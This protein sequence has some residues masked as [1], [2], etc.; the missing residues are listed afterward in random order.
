MG[1]AKM[2]AGWSRSRPDSQLRTAPHRSRIEIKG[3][4]HDHFKMWFLRW[5]STGDA[6]LTIAQAFDFFK[7]NGRF[8]N[9]S[10]AVTM[11]YIIV[12]R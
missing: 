6:M 11:N 8:R 3:P 5:V 2:Q 9:S 10:D 12:C 7:A 1:L 4:Y